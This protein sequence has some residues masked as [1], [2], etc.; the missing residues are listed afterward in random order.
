MNSSE[1]NLSDLILAADGSA[2]FIEDMTFL[3]SLHETPPNSPPKP[4]V[5]P[6][7]RVRCRP[8]DAMAKQLGRMRDTIVHKTR[9]CTDDTPVIRFP[10]NRQYLNIKREV[11]KYRYA[12]YCRC[13]RQAVFHTGTGK[14][15]VLVVALSFAY[16]TSNMEDLDTN[17]DDI[18]TK[19]EHN[20]M[21]W[22]REAMDR[23]DSAYK[24]A[25]T[26]KIERFDTVIE[27]N[28]KMYKN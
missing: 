2:Q 21:N 13:D 17:H 22:K 14:T 25:Q 7:R 8:C 26:K 27:F 28:K 19:M 18:V 4:L 12:D 9:N 20:F 23:K 24:I 6:I 11:G 1:E 3:D 16:H 5:R 10:G 15:S